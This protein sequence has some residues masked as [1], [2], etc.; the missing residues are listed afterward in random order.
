MSDKIGRTQF[1]A[2]S[3]KKDYVKINEKTYTQR[4]SACVLKHGNYNKAMQVWLF[5][6]VFT[7]TLFTYTLS[8]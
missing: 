3:A 2:H 4:Y 1:I 8:L 5:N 7:G 6:T